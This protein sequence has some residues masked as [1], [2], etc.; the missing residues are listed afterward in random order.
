MCHRFLVPEGRWGRDGAEQET[1]DYLEY[2]VRVTSH[3]PDKGQVMGGYYRLFA[4]AYIH[5]SPEASVCGGK[6]SAWLFVAIDSA[7]RPAIH[8]VHG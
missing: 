4:N 8:Y 5:R 3:I 7:T 6:A 2:M 1:M